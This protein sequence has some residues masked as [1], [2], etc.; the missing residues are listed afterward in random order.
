MYV[1]T[2]SDEVIIFYMPFL[3]LSLRKIWRSQK[4]AQ[5]RSKLGTSRRGGGDEQIE[6][7]QSWTLIENELC[8]AS[9]LPWYWPFS[10]T[11]QKVHHSA[12]IRAADRYAGHCLYSV[13]KSPPLISK[14]TRI[15]TSIYPTYFPPSPPHLNPPLF[16][17]FDHKL[18][19]LRYTA[20]TPYYM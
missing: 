14:N 8:A 11:L 4:S 12:V 17:L 15:T 6:D 20:Y 18:A 10:H 2:L 3:G 1:S 5:F 13:I 16:L 19:A 9:L 7:M